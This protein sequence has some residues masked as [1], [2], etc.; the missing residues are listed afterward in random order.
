M[1]GPVTEHAM[2]VGEGTRVRV[3][4]SLSLEDGS[5]NQEHRFMIREE[6][7]RMME[8]LEILKKDDREILALVADGD[9]SYSEIGE[10]TASTRSALSSKTW[11]QLSP[12]TSHWSESLTSASTIWTTSTTEGAKRNAP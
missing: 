4:F 2:T 5:E 8:A 3:N 12:N 9:L 11:M 10:I 7:R 1:D 6:Y